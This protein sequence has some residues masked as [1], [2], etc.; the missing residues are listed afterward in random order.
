MP[1]NAGFLL[2]LYI[3]FIMIFHEWGPTRE[4]V[5]GVY[6]MEV[7]VP[8]LYIYE[9]YG[10]IGGTF[11]NYFLYDMA[12][13][14]KPLN[15]FLDEKGHRVCFKD[16]CF[17]P[18]INFR[19]IRDLKKRSV[20]DF[21]VTCDT[22]KNEITIYDR[23]VF[24]NNPIKI[25]WFDSGERQQPIFFEPQFTL[26]AAPKIVKKEPES[27][28]Q[29]VVETMVFKIIQDMGFDEFESETQAR[30][31]KPLPK[32]KGNPPVRYPDSAFLLKSAKNFYSWYKIYSA[33][34]TFEVVRVGEDGKVQWR[35]DI[36]NTVKLAKKL[37]EDRERRNNYL[38]WQYSK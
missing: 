34:M 1:A 21:L 4:V 12:K 17:G 2:H 33:D 7:R 29:S 3:I 32:Y 24:D 30:F 16:V 9:H 19:E 5:K 15:E 36:P 20:D 6:K 27:N 38:K 18:Y 11:G 26:Y 28:D 14:D 13:A 8:K 35:Q 25:N 23:N 22:Q 31:F 37:Q 10:Y